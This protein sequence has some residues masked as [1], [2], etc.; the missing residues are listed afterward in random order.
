MMS[1]D[2]TGDVL[3]TIGKITPFLRELLDEP[4]LTQR[5]VNDWC[6][7]GKIPTWKVGQDIVSTKQALRERFRGDKAAA[8]EPR[9]RPRG[10]Q[11]HK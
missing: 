11:A 3:R 9:G 2:L 8:A 7:R 10:T 6:Y 4:G 1:D 5:K